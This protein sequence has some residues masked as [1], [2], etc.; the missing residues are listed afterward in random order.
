MRGR[1]AALALAGL[2]LGA[3]GGPQAAPPESSRG[4]TALQAT[5]IGSWGE[6]GADSQFN[7][8]A[9]VAV[10]RMGALYVADA[11]NRRVLVFPAKGGPPAVWT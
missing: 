5:F 4:G 1:A 9:G 11:G 3:C 2:A 10:D 8:P 6:V 7:A